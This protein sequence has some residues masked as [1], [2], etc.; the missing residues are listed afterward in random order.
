MKLVP[1]LRFDKQNKLTVKRLCDDVISSGHDIVSAVYDVIIHC[2][3]HLVYN[4]MRFFVQALKNVSLNKYKL[5][6]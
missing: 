6:T 2:L 3:E 1:W 4:F 5:K